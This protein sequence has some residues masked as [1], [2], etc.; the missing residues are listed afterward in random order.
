MSAREPGDQTLRLGDLTTRVGAQGYGDHVLLIGGAGAGAASWQGVSLLLRR[1]WTVW[2]YDQRGVGSAVDAQGALDIPTLAADAIAL[3]DALEIDRVHLVGHS[4]GA[5][6]AIAVARALPARVRSITG[7][8]TWGWADPYLEHRFAL[9]REIVRHLPFAAAREALAF[10]LVSRPWQTDA[11]RFARVLDSL[12]RTEDDPAWRGLV[13][14]LLAPTDGDPDRLDLPAV[15]ALLLAT[16]GDRMIPAEYTQD[17]A[18]AW[19]QARFQ[20]LGTDTSAHLVHVEE[21]AQ[22]A[23]TITEFLAAGS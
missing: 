4:T 8:C 18:A 13:R 23:R 9:V 2:T 11:R 21:A 12:G 22:T 10:L 16:R 19:P 5:R 7:L 1:N 3:L 17:L 15:R 20:W 14:H 6:T